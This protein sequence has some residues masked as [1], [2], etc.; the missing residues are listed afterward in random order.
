M[1]DR[2]KGTGGDAGFE[3]DLPTSN[4]YRSDTNSV[5]SDEYENSVVS[6]E[7]ETD[8]DM[9]RGVEDGDDDTCSLSD[10]GNIR[11]RRTKYKLLIVG[12]L[13]IIAG[14]IGAAAVLTSKNDKK[15]DE[16]VNNVAAANAF[17]EEEDYTG[18]TSATDRTASTAAWTL[19]VEPESNEKE[20][21]EDR[22]LRADGGYWTPYGMDNLHDGYWT[23]WGSDG[24][25]PTNSPA[26]APT[27]KPANPPVHLWNGDGHKPTNR[28]T[29]PPVHLWNGDG[30]KP[31]NTPTEAPTVSPTDK[32]SFAPTNSPTVSPTDKPTSDP[33][34]APTNS[35]TN[36]PTTN[37]PTNAPTNKPTDPPVHLWNGDG[38]MPTNRP[39][40][41]LTTNKPTIKSFV[42]VGPG[43]CSDG[44]RP[45]RDYDYLGFY[46]LNLNK[47][48]CERRCSGFKYSALE[49]YVVFKP[50]HGMDVCFCFFD[51]NM[52][53]CMG[54]GWNGDGHDKFNNG[55]DLCDDTNLG[56]GLIVNTLH[57][58]NA[59]CYRLDRSAPP[60]NKP[61]K[62]PTRITNKP[63][64]KPS[65]KP[66]SKPTWGSTPRPS[67]RPTHAPTTHRPTKNP[68]NK[69][70]TSSRTI[71]AE[72][73]SNDRPWWQ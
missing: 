58:D 59:M 19:E 55:A 28:P 2:K 54:G 10:D 8:D 29:D 32:P 69:P 68:T 24:H 62:R 7:Y 48:K 21:G 60:T 3:M 26:D 46:I 34:L 23:P 70:T 22:T 61:T 18:T 9:E 13:L 47:Y 51:D 73:W 44:N 49:G 40:N 72:T 33:T 71:D 31:T 4:S 16:R 52:L 53:Q 20:T 57:L 56:T 39:T 42:E 1:N 38:H 41:A 43:I 66:S 50:Q 5:V 65:D 36:K 27:N 35:P 64:G 14:V 30:H 12:G 67:N 15:A 17:A 37:R 63:S 6:D 11:Q 45:T 25:K